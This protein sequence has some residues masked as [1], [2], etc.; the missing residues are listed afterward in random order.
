MGRLSAALVA[1]LALAA[2]AHASWSQPFDVSFAGWDAQAAQV[3][4]GPTGIPLVAWA[5][6]DGAVEARRGRAPPGPIEAVS[7]VG[8]IASSPRVAADPAGNTTVA[9]QAFDGPDAFI[10]SRRIAADGTVEDVRD[11]AAGDV[12]DSPRVAVDASGE[13]TVLWWTD[14]GAGIG[15]Q[16]RDVGAGGQLGMLADISPTGN[17]EDLFDPEL[18]VDPAG[19]PV[20]VWARWDGSNWVIAAA[21]FVVPVPPS[22]QPPPA[23]AGGGDPPGPGAPS[24]ASVVPRRLSA[25]TRGQPRARRAKGIGTRLGLSGAGRLDL[26]SAR[27]SYRLR[28]RRRTSRLR[29]RELDAGSS[30]TLRF[31]LPRPLARKLPLGLGVTL[32]LRARAAAP[33]CGFGA[34]RTLS[35]RT[36]L[37]WV[38]RR[39]AI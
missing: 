8:E 2:P 38:P 4:I 3:A 26:V 9:W 12:L 22:Q 31:K 7:K 19:H 10:Q 18:A 17:G 30:E 25:H 1:T 28:G 36:K 32:K 24:C 14:T 11:L 6:R 16:A 15:V 20:A 27:L 29:T 35:V 23:A 39:S 33:G 21:R 34:A 5:R 13:A 37:I